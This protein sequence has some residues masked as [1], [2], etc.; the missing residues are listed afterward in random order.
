MK[1]ITAF[2]LIAISAFS[3][4]ATSE[5]YLAQA[6]GSLNKTWQSE[7]YELYIPINTWHNRD[8]YSQEKEDG[9][10]EHPWGLGVG[11]YRFD[12]DGDWHSL[13]LIGFQDS[14]NDLEPVAGFA[15]QKIW[16]PSQNTRLGIGYTVGFTMRQ[17]MDYMPIPLVLPLF[18]AEYKQISLQSTYVPGGYEYGNI[19]FTW[20]RWQ[21]K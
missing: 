4:T 18:S 2:F 3:P 16:R 5:D 20:L 21:I 12:E 17:D 8:Y 6:V 11:K 15:F 9:F 7:G 1:F 13:Y 10:N 14:N 19:L